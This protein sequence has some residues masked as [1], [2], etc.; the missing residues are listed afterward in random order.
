M[1]PD[2]SE[3]GFLP[4]GNH[5][6]K[7]VPFVEHFTDRQER[8]H[9]TDLLLELFEYAGSVHASSILFG[10]SFVSAKPT[11]NDIDCVILFARADLIP[12]VPPKLRQEG[13]TIDV[14][15][16]SADH[17]EIVAS[18]RKLFSVT[19][20][21]QNIGTVEVE[22]WDGAPSFDNLPEPSP[23]LLDLAIKFYG[24]RHL[25][26]TPPRRKVLVPIHGIS[27]HAEWYGEVSLLGS[28]NGWTVAPFLYGFQDPTIFLNPKKRRDI[29]DMFRDH[30]T[31]VSQ[32]SDTHSVSVIAHSFGTYIAINYILGFDDP[33]TRFDTLILTGAIIDENL[34]L[35]RLNGKIGHMLNEVAPND[36]WAGWAK[37]ANFSKDELFGKAGS[38][39][40][41]Q[42][43][44]RLVQHRSEIFS[45]TNIIK[46]D[47]IKSRW[48]PTLEANLGSVDRDLVN[49]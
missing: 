42:S 49:E 16:A 47:V 23:A 12:T 7:P 4:V 14:Y 10:G 15:F 25:V 29:V 46:R 37:K 40:F 45:H 26:Q 2:F 44:E 11:P 21:G 24:R 36:R 1:I 27:S 38:G 18:F 9:L 34:D 43:D 32:L 41:S 48:I 31:D 8:L 30:L 3:N 28:L 17:P 19:K 20:S 6:A 35:R 13:G 22:L 39:G 33:P 5:K